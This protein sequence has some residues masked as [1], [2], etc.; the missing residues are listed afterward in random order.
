[1]SR[2][3]TFLLFMCTY[4]SIIR[5]NYNDEITLV[6]NLFIVLYKKRLNFS[7]SDENLCTHGLRNQIIEI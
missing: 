2:Q 7:E 4:K 3:R 1:M 6:I 5:V